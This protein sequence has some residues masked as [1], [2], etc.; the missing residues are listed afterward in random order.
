MFWMLLRILSMPQILGHNQGRESSIRNS[1]REGKLRYSRAGRTSSRKL[2]P[3]LKA[4]FFG[5]I[6]HYVSGMDYRKILQDMTLKESAEDAE[7]FGKPSTQEY[8]IKT[9][10]ASY[11]QRR[12][13]KW[14]HVCGRTQ[15]NASCSVRPEI[16]N[17][18]PRTPRQPRTNFS[19]ICS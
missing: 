14:V 9:G 18:K 17:L 10:R 12:V 8:P 1:S 2:C 13:C 11:R 4:S 16:F 6:K 7:K 3:N 19:L 5:T 15:R